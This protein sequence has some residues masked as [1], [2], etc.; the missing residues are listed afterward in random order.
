MKGKDNISENN[1]IVMNLHRM[2]SEEGFVTGEA[3]FNNHDRAVQQV[4]KMVQASKD[5]ASAL[6]RGMSIA[7]EGSLYADSG[8]EYFLDVNTKFSL[9]NKYFIICF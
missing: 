4:A 7:G 1:G 2:R 3:G 6:K 5:R 9:N 8:Y